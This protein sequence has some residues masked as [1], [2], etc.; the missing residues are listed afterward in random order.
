ME[1]TFS[2]YDY[3]DSIQRID[4][5]LD[6]SD[7]SYED[8]KGIPPRNNLTYLNG[9]NVDV[10]VLFVDLRDS[11][12]L[13][14]KHT[15][16]VLAKIYRSYISELVAIMKGDNTISE[17]YIE[18]DGVWGVFNTTTKAQ[19]NGV[20]ETAGRISSLI[21]IL[22]V[23]LAKKKYSTISVGIGIDDGYSLY[24]KA[25]YKGSGINEVV[26]IGRVVGGAANLCKYGNRTILDRTVMVS[27]IVYDSL[28]DKYKGFLEWNAG[29]GCYQG[30]IH[31]IS[32]NQW[33]ID[34]S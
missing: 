32:M 19:V 30:D 13:S 10:T 8:H 24:I 18:G 5:I 34:N 3:K 29:R 33:V 7:A 26:W 15:K 25:G 27:E 23:K 11:T 4:E 21:Q 6:S 1:A 14:I 16:P 9:Y 17:I 2:S 28:V 31:N 22:N 12:N 20:F